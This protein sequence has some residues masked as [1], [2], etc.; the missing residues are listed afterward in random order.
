MAFNYPVESIIPAL[1]DAL[2]KSPR[3]ILEAAPGAGK[4]TIVPISIL[5]EPCM[6]SGKMIMLEPRR[7]A[8]RAAAARMSSLINEKIGDTVGYRIRMENAVSSKTRIEVITEG[9]LSRMMLDNP[10][11]DGVSLLIFDEFHERSIHADTALAMA[12]EIQESFRPDLKILIMSATLQ[13]DKIRTFLGNPPVI[14]SEG[15]LFEVETE[16]VNSPDTS[17][18]R[19][20][21]ELCASTILR[22]LKNESGDI[23]VFLPGEGEIRHCTGLLSKLRLPDSVVVCPLYGNLPFEK[24]KEAILPDREGRRKIVLATTIAESSLTIEGIRVVV[25][26]GLSRVQE[27]DQASGLSAMKTIRVSKASADQR[28]GRAGRLGPGKCYRLWSQDEDKRLKPF[29]VPEILEADLSS[30]AL[31][32]LK[33][34]ANEKT[35][36]SMPWLDQPPAAHLAAAFSMLRS[37]G[38]VNAEGKLTSEGESLLRM[39]LHPRLASLIIKSKRAGFVELGCELALVLSETA[40]FRKQTDSHDIRARLDILHSMRRTSH[41]DYILNVLD[42]FLS[43][44]GADGRSRNNDPEKAGLLLA[45]AWPERL[46]QLRAQGTFNYRLRNGSGARFVNVNPPAGAD[47]VVIPEMDAGSENARVFLAAPID[48]SDILAAFGKEIK[49]ERVLFWDT[50]SKSVKA[51]LLTSLGAIVFA[52]TPAS[53]SGDSANVFKV[54]AEGIRSEGLGILPWTKEIRSLFNRMNFAASYRPDKFPDIS[55]KHL[56]ETLEDWLIPFLKKSVSSVQDISPDVFRT[57]LENLMDYKQ[58]T[59]LARLAPETFHVPSGSN[60]R[61]DYSGTQP[62][63]HVKLQEMFGLLETPS[64]S[65]GKIR[66]LL[67]LLSPAMRP[68]QIT[69]DLESFWKTTYFQ[70][71][72]DLKARYPK[73]YWPE[74]PYDAEACR[75]VRRHK[76]L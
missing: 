55:E 59:E 7:I 11:L 2:A 27:Y 10:S 69:D 35:I 44:A 22:S 41:N 20:I 65:G 21:E 4:T 28:R 62:V 74:D 33:W 46:A 72:K 71:K 51:R 52:E 25:D 53:L 30:L 37:L 42:K 8:A 49:E 14:S 24:Q 12:L 29:N 70:V 13:T 45:F 60:I 58:S 40:F 19:R 61:I 47:F 17:R 68:V 31:E 43:M 5:D 48:K 3:L 38:A 39:P 18:H 63:L 73:H 26:S 64:I 15:R 76:P 6:A 9:I 50:A 67:H 56:L 75:G 23:L 54:L 34:G 1:K 66:I 36:P 32:M 16:Y 57:A